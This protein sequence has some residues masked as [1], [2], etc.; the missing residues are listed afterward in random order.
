[1]IIFQR[2]AQ[3]PIVYWTLLIAISNVFYFAT[4]IDVSADDLPPAIVFEVDGD[5]LVIEQNDI[6]KA[7]ADSN[8]NSH[9]F[10]CLEPTKIDEYK[11][12]VTRNLGKTAN[13]NIGGEL[14][15]SMVLSSIP[16]EKCNVL[17]PMRQIIAQRIAAFF[18]GERSSL[19]L[20]GFN[21]AKSNAYC[22][23]KLFV[24]MCLNTNGDF[25]AIKE[26]AREKG[27][28]WSKYYETVR[29]RNVDIIIDDITRVIVFETRI[30]DLLSSS[31][32]VI[33][34]SR[35]EDEVRPICAISFPIIQNSMPDS[36]KRSDYTLHSYNGVRKKFAQQWITEKR[37]IR[38]FVAATV[39]EEG[40][41]P[42][43]TMESILLPTRR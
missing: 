24:E 39:D 9:I 40:H 31:C 18:R 38:T 12:F 6:E 16:K 32:V 14:N 29:T 17:G 3:V 34:F 20:E 43:F 5:R 21:P 26:L 7:T 30:A 41:D 37:N 10:V 11:R 25:D 27:L 22:P 1:M 36:G 42:Q 15:G 2:I 23:E 28:D 4:N 13:L 33:D 35:R 8:A 19:A